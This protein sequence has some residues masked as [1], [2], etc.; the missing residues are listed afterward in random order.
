MKEKEG[1]TISR[2]FFDLDGTLAKWQEVSIEELYR[3]G[4]FR[5]LPATK[6]AKYANGIA[7]ELREEGIEVFIL[8]SVLNETARKE[9][10]GWCDEHVPN[11]LREHRLYVPYGSDKAA[12]VRELF[13]KPISQADVLVDDYS[14][15]LVQWTAWGGNA[16]KWLNGIN[17]LGNTFKGKRVGTVLALNELLLKAE[18]RK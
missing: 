15:N 17:G 1:G 6:L 4:Y 7:D 12:F 11:I 10:D 3:S 14:P 8:S 5:E 2:L 16:I 18:I 13:R 9:K